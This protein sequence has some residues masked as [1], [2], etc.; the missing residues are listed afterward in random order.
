MLDVCAQNT[1]FVSHTDVLG[2]SII[3]LTFIKYQIHAKRHSHPLQ[4]LYKALY[5]SNAHAFVW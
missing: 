1:V 2:R 4:F 3:W 5:L